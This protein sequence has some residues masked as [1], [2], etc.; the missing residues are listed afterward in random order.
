MLP[1]NYYEQDIKLNIDDNKQEKFE[2]KASKRDN[3][4]EEYGL[5]ACLHSVISFLFGS[6]ERSLR[7]LSFLWSVV[8]GPW[9][10]LLM[11]AAWEEQ[12]YQAPSVASGLMFTSGM[13]L[14]ISPNSRLLSRTWIVMGAVMVATC[15]I[16]SLTVTFTDKSDVWFSIC[17][18]QTTLYI[19]T[20]AVP[21]LASD[22]FVL[23]L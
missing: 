17:I 13:L 23:D 14:M 18:V 19:L 5:Y 4:Q 6:R 3:I 9:T 8:L 10:G 22:N 16:S 12:R 2:Q 21:V 1:T 7:T 20:S 15:W 11:A